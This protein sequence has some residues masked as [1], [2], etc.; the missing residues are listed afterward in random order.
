[1]KRYLSR[2][3][4]MAIVAGVALCASQAGAATLYWDGTDTTG[5]ADGGD[6]TWNTATTANWDTAAT[7]G[8][9]STWTAGYDAVFG[10][11]SGTVVVANGTAAG[12]IQFDTAG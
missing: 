10:G 11:A 2:A 1:M 9:D 6:G 8:A 3:G 7:G 4:W 12:A 5:D